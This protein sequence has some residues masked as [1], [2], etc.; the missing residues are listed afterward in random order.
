[1]GD[2]FLNDHISYK[3][4]S[5]AILS[6]SH[7]AAELLHII[8]RNFFTNIDTTLKW[9]AT[10][11]SRHWYLTQFAAT[12]PANIAIDRQ[13]RQ[14]SRDDPWQRRL[15]M[16]ATVRRTLEKLAATTFRLMMR[17]S[18]GAWQ[19]R[20]ATVTIQMRDR[21]RFTPLLFVSV[22]KITLHHHRGTESIF[23]KRRLSLG[24]SSLIYRA[25]DAIVY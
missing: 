17:F 21:I 23:A 2:F 18:F 15:Q 22:I 25:N 7:L 12:S 14:F 8:A 16:S 24:L 4:S 20:E 9:H 5:R 6:F 11:I 13:S 1:M 19:H 3:T 10:R